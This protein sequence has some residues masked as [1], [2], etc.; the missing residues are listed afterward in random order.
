MKTNILFSHAVKSK[1]ILRSSLTVA[2]DSSCL[3]GNDGLGYCTGITAEACCNVYQPNAM[4]VSI[5]AVNCDM[6]YEADSPDF[7]C[8][9]LYR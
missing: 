3:T 7:I 8:G 2:C 5:C 6:G 4:G 1:V 9:E